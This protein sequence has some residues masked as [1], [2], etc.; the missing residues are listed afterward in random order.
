M[1][2][3]KVKNLIRVGSSG[4]SFQFHGSFVKLAKVP[5]WDCLFEVSGIRA[6][7]CDCDVFAEKAASDAARLLGVYT[8]EVF[9]LDGFQLRDGLRTHSTTALVRKWLPGPQY[10]SCGPTGLAIELAPIPPCHRIDLLYAVL[11]DAALGTTPRRCENLLVERRL[12]S[13]VLIPVG[14][15]NPFG[16]GRPESGFECRFAQWLTHPSE[17]GILSIPPLYVEKVW[18]HISRKMKTNSERMREISGATVS[19]FLEIERNLSDFL[20]KFRI[21]F[22]STKP[23]FPERNSLDFRKEKA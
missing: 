15:D 9:L 4:R 3:A 6:P 17:S 23:G 10:S 12:G 20:R 14:Y 21:G 7:E 2:E 22:V 5:N 1:I 18:N 13:K 16:F 19:A 8:P 11:V